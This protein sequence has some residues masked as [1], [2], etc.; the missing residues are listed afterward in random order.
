MKKI[1]LLFAALLFAVGGM[2][3]KSEKVR[4]LSLSDANKEWNGDKTTITGN[5]V[6]VSFG[7]E[8]GNAALSWFG[9]TPTDIS[10]YDRL[11]LELSEPSTANV[12]VVV[13]LGGFWGQYHQSILEA[14]ETRLALTLADLK[15]TNAADSDP[16]KVGD[17]VD[18]T[19]V[20]LIYLRS[21]WVQEQVIKVEDFYF[22]N[23]VTTYDEV[24]ETPAWTYTS[25]DWNEAKAEWGGDGMTI[26]KANKIITKTTGAWAGN[27]AVA[28]LNYVATDISGYD[29]LVLELEEA[30]S[31]PVEVVVSDGGFWG[32]KC[33]SAVLAAGATELILTLSELKIT[34]TPGESDT[35]AKG[36]ALDLENVNLIFI[37]TDN[38]TANQVIKVKDFYFAKAQAASTTLVRESL[39]A[40]A[41]GTVCLPFPASV[42]ANITAYEV[43]GVDSKEAP[44]KLYLQ[45]VSSLEAGKAYVYRSTDAED[46]TFTKTGTNDDLTAPAAAD[47]LIGQFSGSV[48]VPVGSYILYGNRWLRVAKANTNSVKN[49]RAYLTLTDDLVAPASVR[50]DAIMDLGSGSVTGIEEKMRDGENEKM[51]RT[52]YFDMNGRRVVKPTKG[53]YIANG[54]KVL[55]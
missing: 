12:E 50:A 8:W 28:W 47:N 45:S 23:D 17:A 29:R 1:Y 35:W 13:S 32:G 15:V 48:Y 52:E 2:Q 3:A 9:G 22:E 46:I 7:E 40:S 36:D 38:G 53:M 30:S 16:Y 42:P 34:G 33:H 21:G 14:G 24:M 19:K 11:V 39:G 26:D 6:T 25:L 20:N 41:Y 5:T 27:N 44:G 55:Y 31:G 49:Y 54:R 51:R 37:R 10:A 4:S 43:V 18:L